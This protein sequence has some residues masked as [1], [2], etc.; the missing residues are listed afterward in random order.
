MSDQHQQGS[1]AALAP[2]EMADA[3]VA[4]GVQKAGLGTG[5]LLILGMLAGLY[6]ALGG[7]FALVVLAGMGEVPH[8]AAQVLAGLVFTLGLI[9]VILGG[10]ELFTG[11][12]LLSIAWAQRE[13]PGARLL[14][15][16]GL[17]YIANLLG[18]LLLAFLAFFAGV[19]QGGEGAVGVAALELAGAKAALPFWTALFSG[20][21]GNLLVCLAVWLTFAARS[22]TD[23]V[24]AIVP[25]IAAFVAA[26]L[27]HSVANMFLIPFGLIIKTLAPAAFWTEA[28]LQATAFPALTLG[29]FLANLVPVTL[30]NMIG[31]L[32]VA[33]SYW[34]VYLRRR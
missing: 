10:A 12:M 6:V 3:A 20:I 29:G 16:W 31:G 28:D 17:A 18:S 27:E 4:Q 2:P 34:T 25:P 33:A 15:A 9:L 5:S 22:F 19:H 7:L 14:R 11:N 26:G 32:L 30:G 21:L 24:L 1:I 23:K 8:G 13:V